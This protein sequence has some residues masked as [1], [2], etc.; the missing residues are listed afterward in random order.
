MKEKKF[1]LTK[2]NELILERYIKKNNLLNENKQHS[3]PPRLQ[4][5]TSLKSSSSNSSFQKSSSMSS[6]ETLSKS[7]TLSNVV[8]LVCSE[9]EFGR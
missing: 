2:M 6:N 9:N 4:N 1:F 8:S 3:F 7:V 5:L